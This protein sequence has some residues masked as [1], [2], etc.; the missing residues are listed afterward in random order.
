[1]TKSYTFNTSFIIKTGVFCLLLSVLIGH[2][3]C[4]THKYD[5]SKYKT[6]SSISDKEKNDCSN[7]SDDEESG[8]TKETKDIFC[9]AITNQLRE[10]LNFL[11]KKTYQHRNGNCPIFIYFE[12]TSPPPELI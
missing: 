2:W 3:F 5:F 9:N 12:I 6:D 1:M 10:P 7:D 4:F 11:G 8:K